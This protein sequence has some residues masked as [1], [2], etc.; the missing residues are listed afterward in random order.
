[1]NG[2]LP[3]KKERHQT[4]LMSYKQCSSKLWLGYSSGNAPVKQLWNNRLAA[5]H[6]P[7]AIEKIGDWKK[8]E[9]LVQTQSFWNNVG[10][11]TTE[12]SIGIRDNAAGIMIVWRTSPPLILHIHSLHQVATVTPS[13]VPLRRR[14]I[15]IKK[16]HGIGTNCKVPSNWDSAQMFVCGPNFTTDLIGESL[17]FPAARD[18]STFVL[19]VLSDS[20]HCLPGISRGWSST[21]CTFGH[22]HKLPD[23]I[24]GF[25]LEYLLRTWSPETRDLGGWWML[26][27]LFQASQI[28]GSLGYF[29]FLRD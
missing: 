7:L 21:V 26:Y 3:L 4:S 24:T 18:Q 9:I 17:S 22:S 20:K 8:L 12:H 15:I 16:I 5:D 1:M 6:R 23:I 2:A 19:C 10:A 28:D 13:H 27:L 14:E 11:R 29:W 25:A